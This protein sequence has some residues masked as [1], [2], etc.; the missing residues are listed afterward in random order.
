MKSATDLTKSKMQDGRPQ[1]VKAYQSWAALITEPLTTRLTPLLASTKI[2]PNFVTLLSLFTGISAGMLFALQ[3]WM[4]GA[5]LFEFSFF[6][7]TLDGKL[8]RMRNMVSELGTRLDAIADGSRKPACFLGISLC[9]YF[10]QSPIL[11][12][13]T[14]VALLVHVGIHKLY[15]YAAVSEY[16]LEFPH[17]HRRFVRRIAPRAI[18]LY[19]FFDE[20]SIEFVLFPLIGGLVGMPDGAVWFLYGAATV[21]ALS[22]AKWGLLINHKRKNRYHLAYQDWAGTGGNLDKA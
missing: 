16:D 10:Q 20:Q 11:A 14:A 12:I 15:G 13:L 22:L 9:F 2:H 4:W 5:M 17:F 19:T 1:F 6:F 21:T 18:A 8:A 3:Q 7:D